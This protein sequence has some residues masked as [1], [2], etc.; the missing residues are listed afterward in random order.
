[1]RTLITF[2]RGRLSGASVAD[3]VAPYVLGELFSI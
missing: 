2:V 1:M 3:T